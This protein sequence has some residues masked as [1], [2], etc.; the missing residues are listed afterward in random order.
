MIPLNNVKCFLL[1]CK[2]KKKMYFNKMMTSLIFLWGMRGGGGGGGGWRGRRWGGE[3]G[4]QNI[5][6]KYIGP[7]LHFNRIS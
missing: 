7:S 5:I 2:P 6:P 3:S 4:C 1:S